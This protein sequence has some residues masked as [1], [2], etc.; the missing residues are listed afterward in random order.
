MA[1]AIGVV[2]DVAAPEHCLFVPSTS[3]VQRSKPTLQLPAVHD[4]VSA[5]F[6]RNMCTDMHQLQS[7]AQRLGIPASR[8]MSQ[9]HCAP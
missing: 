4:N 5:I 3:Q 1:G 7:R 6:G 9:N 2:W 8:S